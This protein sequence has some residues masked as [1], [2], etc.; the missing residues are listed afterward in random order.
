MFKKRLKG[1]LGR[2]GYRRGSKRCR[3]GVTM[4]H[5]PANRGQK[6]RTHG[7]TSG[8]K[9]LSGDKS[10]IRFSR[11]GHS[12]FILEYLL[13]IYKTSYSSLFVFDVTQI[14]ILGD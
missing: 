8:K 12:Q 9:M 2:K 5:A 6:A 7:A 3:K 13:A 14:A 10:V 4:G 1:K 11:L